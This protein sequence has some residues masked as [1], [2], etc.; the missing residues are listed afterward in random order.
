MTAALK[1][2]DNFN[3]SSMV[4]LTLVDSFLI[5]VGVFLVLGM[6]SDF[7]LYPEQFRYYILWLWILFNPFLLG[8]SFV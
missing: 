4:V 8:S 5:Q 3:I 7:Q 6:I 1:L 2:S